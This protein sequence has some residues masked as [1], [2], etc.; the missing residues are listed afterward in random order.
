VG[1]SLRQE[2]GRGKRLGREGQR[3]EGRRRGIEGR[4]DERERDTDRKISV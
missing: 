2:P 4:R 3:L 1:S